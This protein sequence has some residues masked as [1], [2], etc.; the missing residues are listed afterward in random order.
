MK[1]IIIFLLFTFSFLF[2]QETDTLYILETTDIHGNIYPYDYFHDEPAD[3]GLAKIYTKVV[4]FR[5]QHDNVML[6]DAGDLIQGTPM[7]YYFNKVETSL[8]NPMIL[9]LNYMRYDAMAVGNHDI[10]QGLFVYNKAQNESHFPWLSANSTLP[11]MSTYF[12]P[13]AIYDINGIRVGIIGMTTP[14]IPMWLDPHLYPGIHWDDMVETAADYVDE[15]RDEVDVLIGLFHAGLNE[16]YSAKT[17]ESLGIPNENA[18]K[19]VA[20]EVP[21]FDVILAGH[22]HREVANRIYENGGWSTDSQYLHH[23]KDEVNNTLLMN[24]G[25]WGRNLGVVKIILQKEDLDKI[26]DQRLKI[27]ENSV[28][29]ID[30]QPNNMASNSPGFEG[31][32]KIVSKDD[33]LISMKDVA[34]SEAILQLT[35]Y[36]HKKTL[37][38][39]RTDIATATETLSMKQA[40]FEDNP[41]VELINKAQMDYTGADISFAAAFSDQL[42]IPAGPIRIKDVYSMYPYENFLYLVEMTGRQIK[43]FLEYSANYYVMDEGKI[44]ANPDMRGYNYDMAEG[45]EY[46]IKVEKE[47]GKKKKENRNLIEDI[48]LVSTGKPL[49]MNKI[50]K[51]AMNSYRA[52]GGGGH[53]AAA[54]ASDVKILSKSNEEMRNILTDYIKKTGEISA[55]VDGNWEIN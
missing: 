14:G 22:S 30:T 24:A 29:N 28:K 18:S 6:L 50:Y 35:D 10:E 13:Y 40:R 4:E 49:D 16:D 25:S 48:R 20:E 38:Y 37:E 19:L 5:K 2:A 21:G 55:K 23:E 31:Q 26:K 53:M 15:I 33:W 9:T 52:T 45:I 39:I 43:D 3:Y 27:K 34:P 42:V 51:V 12:E 46:K 11:D 1:F 17:T 54:G 7:S 8:P 47:K 32:W 36:Y 41:I 44:V